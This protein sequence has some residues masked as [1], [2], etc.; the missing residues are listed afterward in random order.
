MGE[1]A[2][3]SADGVT[4]CCD[5]KPGRK[6]R[7]VCLEVPPVRG[8]VWSGRSFLTKG[9]TLT[10]RPGRAQRGSCP[11]RGRPSTAVLHLLQGLAPRS[12]APRPIRPRRVRGHLPEGASAAAGLC[13]LAPEGLALRFHTDAA[14]RR[15]SLVMFKGQCVSFSTESG[16]PWRVLAI[17]RPVPGPVLARRVTAAASVAPKL[18]TSSYK[19]DDGCTFHAVPEASTGF[20]WEDT[21]PGASPPLRP[22]ETGGVP[23]QPQTSAPQGRAQVAPVPGSP[24]GRGASQGP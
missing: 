7:A 10:V 17:R 3:R 20:S 13:G 15:G 18:V 21:P 1:P 23:S 5:Q 19:W 22:A 12:V 9:L 6:S 4:S 2:G 24:L 8:E 11:A 14:R 16:W